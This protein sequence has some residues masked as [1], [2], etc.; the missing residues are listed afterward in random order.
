[1]PKVLEITNADASTTLVA[2]AE[3]G[4]DV[5][6]VSRI[7]DAGVAAAKK[8]EQAMTAILGSAVGMASSL[9]EALDGS[10]VH[11]ATLEVG[12]QL[13]TSGNVYVVSG[14]T[15][16]AIKVTLTVPGPGAR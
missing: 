12:I 4:D 2:I 9:R 11:T 15:Q 7:G 8:A 10:P 1:M 14:E 3:A 5:Q 6:A 16:A 13:T